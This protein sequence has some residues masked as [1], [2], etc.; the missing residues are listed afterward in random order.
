MIYQFNIARITKTTTTVLSAVAVGIIALVGSLQKIALATVESTPQ[1][2]QQ[3]AATDAV[4]LKNLQTAYN[5]ESNANARYLAF[6][7]KAKEEGYHQVATLFEAA[8]QAEAIHANNHAQLIKKMGAT[9]QAKIETPNVK[10]TKENLEE[11]INGE[12]YERDTMY[13]GFIEQAQTVGNNEA[14]ETFTYAVKAEKEHAKYYTEAKNNL[15][16]WKEAKTTFFVCPEC[17]FTTSAMTFD[18]CPVCGTGKG[19][20]AQVR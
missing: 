19:S 13:P 6:S 20:F 8:A 1:I 14:I 5:G 11:A 18:V 16:N 12:S 4:T 7:K 17:G 2:A 15:E 9:P 10:S 3:I